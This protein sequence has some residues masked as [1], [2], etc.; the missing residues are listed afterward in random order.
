MTY[1][2]I[3]NSSSLWLNHFPWPKQ[4]THKYL[5][6]HCLILGGKKQ[7]GA[8]KLA[9]K[10]ALR[11]GSGVVTLACTQDVMSEYANYLPS[12]LVEKI[13]DTSNFK[14]LLLEKKVDSVLLGPAAGVNL[15]LRERVLLTL[16]FKKP[17][18]LDAD[19]LSVFENKPDL[20]FDA[21]ASPCILT[22]HLGEF[23]KLFPDLKEGTIENVQKA[24]LRSNAIVILKGHKTIIASPET[25][26]VAIN[27][28]GLPFLATAGSGDVLAGIIASLLSQKLT[29]WLASLI[30]VW[31]HA[32]CSNE[33]GPGLISDDIP[34]LIP[35]VL[36]KLYK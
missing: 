7:T 27:N 34:D 6:G 5:R 26:K 21:I 10:G 1:E 17:C 3:E 29:A 28:N 31:V 9:A 30:G 14:D 35:K 23:Q 24:A 32:E 20:L 2:L 19:A 18:V 16:G 8:T 15:Q 25:N 33:F 12:L 11:S 4:E 13:L 36:Q 22:P